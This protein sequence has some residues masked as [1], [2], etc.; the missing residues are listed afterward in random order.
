MPMGSIPFEP[1]L[2]G[3]EPNIQQMLE[4]SAKPLGCSAQRIILRPEEIWRH[5]YWV[6]SGAVR[7]YYLDRDG[8]EHNKAFFV[9]GEFFWPVTQSL[10]TK[11]CGFFIETLCESVLVTWEV[12]V[13]KAAFTDTQWPRFS[14]PWVEGLLNAK[15]EREQDWLQLNASQRYEKLLATKPDWI[16]CIPDMHLASYLGITP[17]SLSRI[18][19]QLNK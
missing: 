12:T 19:R 5:C 4:Q 13:F 15:M 2:K 3:M 1:L 14:L 16:H 11:P 9:D 10:Q 7:L 18:K 8:K 6:S 17:E